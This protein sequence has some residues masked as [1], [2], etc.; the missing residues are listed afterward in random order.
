MRACFVALADHHDS[1]H[2]HVAGVRRARA[3]LSSLPDPKC[4]ADTAAGTRHLPAI[5]EKVKL[6][7]PIGGHCESRRGCCRTYPAVAVF[8]VL[9]IIGFLIKFA[10]LAAVVAFVVG[11]LAARALRGTMER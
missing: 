7:D 3:E 4:F 5:D 8:I 6:T 11:R 1:E 10:I 9:K 2:H